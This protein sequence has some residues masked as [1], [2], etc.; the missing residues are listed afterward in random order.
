MFEFKNQEVEQ[1]NSLDNSLGQILNSE[2]FQKI[3]NFFGSNFEAIAD[4]K[5]EIDN[6]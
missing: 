4:I 5:I 1:K 2:D 6:S 3:K